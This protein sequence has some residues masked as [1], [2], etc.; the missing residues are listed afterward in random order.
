MLVM[1]FVL[2]CI[3]AWATDG[4]RVF[5]KTLA[6]PMA[7][8]A[9][10]AMFPRVA[11]TAHNPWLIFFDFALIGVAAFI[12]DYCLGLRLGRHGVNGYREDSVGH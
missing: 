1:G 3:G 10:R 9:A 12:G 8:F 2:G 4:G 7:L 6:P 11:P 5:M